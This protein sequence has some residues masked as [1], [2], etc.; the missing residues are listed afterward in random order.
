MELDEAAR[1]RAPVLLADRV[2]VA[3]FDD[4]TGD[5]A[6]AP[7]GTAVADWLVQGLSRQ[8]HVQVVPIT[9]TLGTL[10]TVGVT[11]DP[12]ER[13]AE[14]TGAGFVVSGVILPKGDSLSV[15]ATV[16]DARRRRIAASLDPVHVPRDRAVEALEPLR[17]RVVAALA[18]HVTTRLA[19][20]ATLT[21]P[22]AFGAYREYAAGLERFAIA[23]WAGA[24][25]R[26]LRAADADTAHVT[27]L[28]MAALAYGNLAD[29]R[30]ADSVV[31][32]LAPRRG[33]LAPLESLVF[34]AFAASLRGD[35][36]ATYDA[37][38]RAARLAPGTL[39]HLRVAEEA[40]ALNRPREA[41]RVLDSLDPTRGELR[42]FRPYWSDLALAHH[43][44]GEYKQELDAARQ[45][46]A[47]H[48]GVPDM[49]ALE[50]RALAGLGR[51][52]RLVAR[53]D[54][55]AATL[56]ATR[57]EALA[58]ECA[59]HDG[60]EP[61]T[62]LAD[63][64]LALAREAAR[65]ESSAAAALVV[66]EALT[67]TVRWK[68]ARSLADSLLFMLPYDADLRGQRGIVA[69]HLGDES[70]ARDVEA[71]LSLPDPYPDFGRRSLWRARL[72]ATRGNT[73]STI[74]LLDRALREG[75]SFE[76][77]LHADPDLAGVRASA[78]FKAWLQPKE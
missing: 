5:S 35:H 76:R 65:R 74:V 27:P 54:A 77:P 53:L 15:Q 32:R 1:P 22:P 52:E 72:A 47:L 69:L 57:L 24:A 29:P 37:A 70:T 19:E 23:D 31:Q 13:L 75:L 18:A 67:T 68:E 71:R 9:V 44:V 30:G 36:A 60:A 12:V 64:A 7:L 78:A 48:Q 39:V 28:L 38:R 34:D 73:D 50:W 4:R 63:R 20:P 41:L 61:A 45:A 3:P 40:M 10:Q 49:L 56:G 25:E 58:H 8:G 42:G 14:E 43:M 6:L 33:G 16:T 17:R 26:F 2:A 11:A 21:G 46:I 66:V 59:A 62:A 51:C 55:E